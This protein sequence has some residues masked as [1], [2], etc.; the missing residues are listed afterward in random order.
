ML[1]KIGQIQVDHLTH[2]E[3]TIEQEP[4]ERAVPGA[5]SLNVPTANCRT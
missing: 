1:V 2:P 4:Q 3:T 5:D